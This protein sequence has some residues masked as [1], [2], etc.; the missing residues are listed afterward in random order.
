[1]LLLEAGPEEPEVTQVPGFFT[2]LAG[3]NLDWKYTTE[4]NGKS[5]LA[6][7]EGKCGWPRG[8]TMG[9][10][11][12]INAMAYVRGNK[13]DYDE[14]ALMGNEGWSYDDV[15]ALVFSCRRRVLSISYPQ[16]ISERYEEFPD[17]ESLS[18]QFPSP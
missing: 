8:K 13:A 2:A 15:S 18:N 3:S 4:S 1:V 12:A 5:C 11:T 17:I 9:G 14:W 6:F 7:P 10:S 16:G